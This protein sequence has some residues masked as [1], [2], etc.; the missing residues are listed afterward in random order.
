MDVQYNLFTF[1]VIW[2][3]F[4]WLFSRRLPVCSQV[5]L[6]RQMQGARLLALLWGAHAARWHS[7]NVMP[8]IQ[9]WVI[10][11][12]MSPQRK[13]TQ[14]VLLLLCSPQAFLTGGCACP[15]AP[16][17]PGVS[18]LKETHGGRIFFIWPRIISLHSSIIQHNICHHPCHNLHVQHLNLELS[19][20]F[21]VSVPTFF[22]FGGICCALRCSCCSSCFVSHGNE[23]VLH[24]FVWWCILRGISFVIW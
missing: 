11:N 20:F 13:P 5:F 1:N 23:Y 12:V 22:S 10:C 7:L 14:N 15:T 2:W 16:R 9:Y 18:G 8:C 3:L 21:I 19:T 4:V 6:D 24:C 17:H